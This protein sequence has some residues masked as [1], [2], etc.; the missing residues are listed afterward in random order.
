MYKFTYEIVDI[1][2]EAGELKQSRVMNWYFQKQV[3][4]RILTFS[5][6]F[7]RALDAVKLNRERGN[8]A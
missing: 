2:F 8:Y 5:Q 7:M 3:S 4:E 1:N 6:M